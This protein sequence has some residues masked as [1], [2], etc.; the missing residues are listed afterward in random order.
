MP[1]FYPD[2]IE[3]D[4]DDFLEACDSKEIKEVIEHLRKVGYEIDREQSMHEQIFSDCLTK[5]SN[6]YLSL[7]SEE[8]AMLFAI[9][10]RF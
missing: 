5:I 2:S 9:A 6:N 3:I 8:E 10:Q 7:T 1:T 4:I